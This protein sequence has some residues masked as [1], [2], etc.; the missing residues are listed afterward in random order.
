L[1]PWKLFEEVDT[2]GGLGIG[3]LQLIQKLCKTTQAMV[4]LE[5]LLTLELKSLNI[6]HLFIKDPKALAMT[7]LLEFIS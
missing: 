3:A 7:T 4:I 6:C 2:F 5:A 1:N